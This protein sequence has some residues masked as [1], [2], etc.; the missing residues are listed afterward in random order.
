MS[1]GGFAVSFSEILPLM[2]SPSSLC[3][4]E[5]TIKIDSH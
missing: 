2:E 4:K 1:N 3:I 5:R